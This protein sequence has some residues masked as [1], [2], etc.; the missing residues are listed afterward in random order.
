MTIEITDDMV[1][2]TAREIAAADGENPD[3]TVNYEHY[4]AEFAKNFNGKPVWNL[5]VG[6]SR[7]A[8]TAVAPLIERAVLEKA[9]K[10]ICAHS[11]TIYTP[12]GLIPTA[13]VEHIVGD[14]LVDLAIDI[15]ALKETPL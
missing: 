14:M 1:E 12:S 9:A 3:E 15:R 11:F 7:A 4:G 10:E 6:Q 5:Y 8:L 13:D 2:T